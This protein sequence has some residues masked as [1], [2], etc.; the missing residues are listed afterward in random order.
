[1]QKLALAPSLWNKK[2]KKSIK[3][4]KTLMNDSEAV[5]EARCNLRSA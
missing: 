3:I 1:M 4:K 5:V 2:K